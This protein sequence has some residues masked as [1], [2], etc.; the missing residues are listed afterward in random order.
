VKLVHLVG[1][2]IKKFRNVLKDERVA[3][4]KHNCVVAVYFIKQTTCFGPCTGPSSGLTL[5]VGG[6]Y[7]VRVFLKDWFIT[8]STRSRC[9]AVQS[10]LKS[11]NYC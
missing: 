4:S 2:I 5:C 6:D 7:T 8:G 11:Y 9:F 10:C 3:K 1:F